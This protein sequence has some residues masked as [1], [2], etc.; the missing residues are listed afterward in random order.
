MSQYACS[1]CSISRAAKKIAVRYFMAIIAGF[2]TS[3]S[4]VVFTILLQ[5]LHALFHI[6]LLSNSSTILFTSSTAF[7]LSDFSSSDCS[8]PAVDLLIPLNISAIFSSLRSPSTMPLLRSNL[9]SSVIKRL[10]FAA[11]KFLCRLELDVP[12]SSTCGLEIHIEFLRQL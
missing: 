1:I 5:N 11:A 12:D 10:C 4:F 9:T 7:W 2:L 3:N 6:I 8:V